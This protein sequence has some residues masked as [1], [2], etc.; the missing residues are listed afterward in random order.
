MLC[1]RC[2]TV[3]PDEQERCTRCRGSLAPPPPRSERV[4]SPAASQGAPEAAD[5]V[6]DTDAEG[7]DPPPPVP[8]PPPPPGNGLP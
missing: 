8:D 1:P 6:S 4:L 7:Y 3:N 5:A 2:G